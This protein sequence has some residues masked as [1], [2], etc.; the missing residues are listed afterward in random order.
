MDISRVRKFFESCRRTEVLEMTGVE[1]SP[2]TL[3][4]T[5]RVVKQ[6]FTAANNDDGVDNEFR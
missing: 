5:D 1:C 4:G 6:G 3:H 2:A